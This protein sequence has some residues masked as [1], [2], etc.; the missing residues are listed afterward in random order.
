MRYLNHQISCIALETEN[1]ASLNESQ[2]KL[3]Q[4]GLFQNPAGSLRQPLAHLLEVEKL[5]IK[6]DY[7]IGTDWSA[8]TGSVC[9][10]RRYD[11]CSFPLFL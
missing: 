5:Y 7:R 10:S 8:A 4:E 9:Q 3:F 11:E 6:S 2:P 1:W